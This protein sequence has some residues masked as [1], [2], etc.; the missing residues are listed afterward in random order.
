M[1]KNF[2]AIFDV[3]GDICETLSDHCSDDLVWAL[4]RQLD[5]DD[6]D[7]APHVP[8]RWRSKDGEWGCWEKYI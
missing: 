1:I 2:L 8:Y 3:D 7:C 5:K 6:P 4:C